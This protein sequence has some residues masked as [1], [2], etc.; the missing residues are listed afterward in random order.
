MNSWTRTVHRT[1]P[2]QWNTT[3]VILQTMLRA[4]LICWEASTVFNLHFYSFCHR[5]CT[6]ATGGPVSGRSPRPL[7]VWLQCRSP[8]KNTKHAVRSKAACK[9]LSASLLMLSL[10]TE[11]DQRIKSVVEL[12]FFF[13]WGKKEMQWNDKWF[14]LH[15][16][17][18]VYV[19]GQG[20]KHWHYI[21]SQW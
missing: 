16:H 4:W 20:I 8:V 5:N 1:E 6:E 21:I 10:Q 12:F 18:R 13:F 14:D 7:S 9:A 2:L 17:A 19:S 11:S 3:S 15:T